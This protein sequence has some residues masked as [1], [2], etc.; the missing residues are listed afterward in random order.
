M[1]GET[2]DG[3]FLNENFCVNPDEK[4][5]QNNSFCRRGK[6]ARVCAGKLLNFSYVTSLFCHSGGSQRW[7][8]TR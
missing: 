5:L 6:Q 3:A 2:R 8:L 7:R 1:R 4:R